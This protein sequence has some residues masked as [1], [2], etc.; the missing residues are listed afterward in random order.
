MSKSHIAEITCPKC[1]CKGEFEVWDSINADLHPDL[2]DKL[3]SNDLFMYKCPIC[4]AHIE[5]CYGTLYHDMTHKFMLFFDYEKS[6]D[7]DYSPLQ[8]PEGLGMEGY[9]FRVVFGL[10]HLK[11][12]IVILEQGLDDLVIEHMKYMTSHVIMPE[13][14]E[15]GYRLLFNRTEEATEEFP[16]GTIYFS[17][18]DPEQEKI[19][20]IRFAM[21][22]YHEHRLACEI[23]PRM[24]I[25]NGMCI[26]EEWMSMQMKKEAL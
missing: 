14:A 7:F 15:K 3:F 9:T 18:I 1:N 22:N 16:F 21:D 6:E 13:I 5:I 25:E 4:G 11:E 26:D 10:S 23:D 24:H 19:F 17:Y 20:T 2:R 12:K 8:M